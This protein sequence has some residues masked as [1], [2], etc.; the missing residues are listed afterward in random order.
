M[1]S[2]ST[3]TGRSL[4]FWT[5]R[6]R[7]CWQS[8]R[9]VSSTASPFGS[10][11]AGLMRRP[12]GLQRGFATAGAPDKAPRSTRPLGLAA[13]SSNYS[14]FTR[15]SIQSV[16]WPAG[17]GA[18]SGKSFFDPYRSGVPRLIDVCADCV[19]FSERP[20][21]SRSLFDSAYASRET[22]DNSEGVQ[23]PTLCLAFHEH[24]RAA[25]LSRGSVGTGGPSPATAV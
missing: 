3:S 17:D 16:T 1:E 24:D 2:S 18:R 12:S 10:N 9:H 11:R 6:L 14:P 21:C 4:S 8:A 15:Y 20:P 23:K 22:L 13:F 19:A 25:S 7:R 5:K